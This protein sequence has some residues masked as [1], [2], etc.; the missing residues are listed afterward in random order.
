MDRAHSSS[1]LDNSGGPLENEER[2]ADEIPNKA[3]SKLKVL[4]L[5]WIAHR[6]PKIP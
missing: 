6:R 3:D 1:G 4:G 5:C 2:F